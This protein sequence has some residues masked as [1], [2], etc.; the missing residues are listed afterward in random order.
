MSKYG[1]RVKGLIP[2]TPVF[3][4]YWSQAVLVARDFRRRSFL[5][6][7]IVSSCVLRAGGNRVLPLRS[8]LS[9][10]KYLL[11]PPKTRVPTEASFFP[12]ILHL[13]HE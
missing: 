3:L 6:R 12:A 7:R 2:R 9:G 1:N 8:L 13:Q 4:M 11:A 5:P 10:G